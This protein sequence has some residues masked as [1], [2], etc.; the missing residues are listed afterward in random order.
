METI[1]INYNPQ[2]N[3]KNEDANVVIKEKIDA[4]LDNSE[5]SKAFGLLLTLSEKLNQNDKYKLLEHYQEKIYSNMNAKNVFPMD[6][7]FNTR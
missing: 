6:P 5:Y 7:Y 1:Q 3:T 2:I 4:Y